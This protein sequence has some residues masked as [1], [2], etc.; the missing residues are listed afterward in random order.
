[1]VGGGSV[2]VGFVRLVG[3]MVGLGWV[4][5][6]VRLGV[7]W[8]GLGGGVPSSLKS[9]TQRFEGPTYSR[10]IRFIKWIV[11]R[12]VAKAVVSKTLVPLVRVIEEISRLGVLMKESVWFS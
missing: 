5:W 10:N 6:F 12:L 4:G 1:M 11:F 7:R 2:G 8:L 3:W 9:A